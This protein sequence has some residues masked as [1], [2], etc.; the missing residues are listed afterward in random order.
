MRRPLSW[1]TFRD[2]NWTFG[3]IYGN[4]I[5]SVSR[6]DRRR[7]TEPVV[8]G[9]KG[10]METHFLWYD[11]VRTTKSARIALGRLKVFTVVLFPNNLTC[12]KPPGQAEQA[13]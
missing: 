4:G 3:S 1:L 13:I 9:E 6:V 10:L 11:E 8:S 2:V 5:H 7:T 12:Q